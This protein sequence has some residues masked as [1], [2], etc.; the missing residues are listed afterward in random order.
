M[1]VL[2][3]LVGVPC[4]APNAEKRRNPMGSAAGVRPAPG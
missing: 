3:T 2:P 4:T 1:A